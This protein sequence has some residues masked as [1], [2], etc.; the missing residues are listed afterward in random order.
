MIEHDIVRRVFRLADLLQDD[1]ALA[2]EFVR[3][4]PAVLENVGENVDRQRQIFRQHLGVVTGSFAARVGVEIAADR[5]DLDRDVG[6]AAALGALERHML[7]QVRDAVQRPVHGAC[8]PRP[9]RRP[10]RPDVTWNR[11]D[12]EVSVSRP[13]RFPGARA[14][15][16]LMRRHRLR[17]AR[18][19]P[20]RGNANVV[21]LGTDQSA[22]R[23]GSCGRMPVAR[24]TATGTADGRER[25]SAPVPRPFFARAAMPTALCGSTSMPVDGEPR[26]LVVGLRRRAG[27]HEGRARGR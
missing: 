11:R 6:G 7:E 20:D 22:S 4:E 23:G 26:D 21:R 17:C 10:T 27:R 25:T 18:A 12:R 5:F 3:I 1:V 24:S 9:R 15:W 13:A 16:A 2:L 19:I 14:G 8:R